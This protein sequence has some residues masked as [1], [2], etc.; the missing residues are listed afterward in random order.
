MNGRGRYKFKVIKGI[1]CWKSPEMD[2]FMPLSAEIL[3]RVLMLY[4]K[5]I[6]NGLDLWNA[7]EIEQK[8]MI[9]PRNLSELY[10]E[11]VHWMENLKSIFGNAEPFD[12]GH[13]VLNEDF[14]INLN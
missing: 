14:H 5:E 1:L 9:S 2:R 13:G 6:K 7:I 4:E 3:T 10:G 8:E 11:L 12:G